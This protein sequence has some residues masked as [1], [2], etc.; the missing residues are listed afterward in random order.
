MQLRRPHVALGGHASVPTPAHVLAGLLAAQVELSGKCHP[1][2]KPCIT[3]VSAVQVMH[4]PL[5]FV[6]REVEMAKVV[7]PPRI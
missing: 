3:A 2:R 7:R 4:G 1:A 6:T 5:L